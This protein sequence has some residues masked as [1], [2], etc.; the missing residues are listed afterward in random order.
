MP[1][2]LAPLAFFY[3]L[4]QRARAAAYACGWLASKRLPAKVVSVGNLS[5]GGTGKT[6]MVMRLAAWLAGRG[7][8][9]AVLTRGYGRAEQ[10]PLVI[11]GR[12]DL[13]KYTSDLMG[14]EPILLARRLP[15]VTIGIGA[16]RFALAQKI[17]EMEAPHPPDVFLLDDGFQHLRLRR[18]LDLVLIDSSAPLALESVLPAGRLREPRAALARA[19]LIVLTRANQAPP[20]EITA[21]VRRYNRQAPIFR[22]TT[23][24]TGVFEAGT[25]RSANLFALKQGPVLAFCG[26]GHPQAFWDDLERWGF[27]LA[28]TVAFPDH[29]RYTLDDIAGLTRAAE[30]HHARALLLTEKDLVNLTVVP[31]SNPPWFYCRVELAL[32]DE[33]AFFDTVAERLGLGAG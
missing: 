9:V 6:P 7:A 21:A 22:S 24:L 17:L 23:K 27:Q 29:H 32:E 30:R 26:I 13:E 16:D 4:F 3:G 20:A 5:V 2:L 14:D 18:D 25:H 28:A 19:G 12:G 11:N 10:L 8:H 33:A 31:P 1:W 15:D